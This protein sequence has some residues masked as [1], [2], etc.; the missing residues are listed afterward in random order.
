MFIFFF[1]SRR[2]HTRCALVTG[3]QTCAL[4]ICGGLFTGANRTDFYSR[5]QG[6]GASGNTPLKGAL[7]RAA[8][9]FQTDGPWKD[10]NGNELTC[11]Q[12][13]AILTTDGYWNHNS[14]YT[15]VGNADA[16]G[17]TDVDGNAPQYPDTYWDTLADV[18]YK[19]WST[20]L[21]DDMDDNVLTSAADPASWQHMV[22]FG[23]SIGLQ[24]TLDPNNPPPSPWNVDPDRKR[25]LLNSSH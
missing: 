24:G 10:S 9:Y 22:T 13:Y 21:R 5:L 11:R 4:P 16:A 3:V 17:N 6:A 2:R 8:R 18:A 20:D 12:N 19:Y 15:N 1:S 23:V 25:N 14:G 7:Q